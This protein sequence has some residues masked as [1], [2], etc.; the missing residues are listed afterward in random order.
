MTFRI[1]AIN[2]CHLKTLRFTII[3]NGELYNFK[4]IKNELGKK[5]YFFNSN[6]DTEVFLKGFIEYGI[7]F[8][9]K[10]TEFSQFQFTIK[11]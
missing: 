6:G 8:L 4:E 3:Y 2:R 1:I 9:K 10:L 5:G 11:N 7:N